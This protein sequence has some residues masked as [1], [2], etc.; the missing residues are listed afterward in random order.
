MR[1][2]RSAVLCLLVICSQSVAGTVARA[3]EPSVKPVLQPFVESHSLA[4]AVTVVASRDKV[5]STEAVGYADIAAK[6][7]ME[8]NSLFWIA[9]MSKPITGAAVMVLVD[10]GKLTID[11]PVEKYLPEFAKQTMIEDEAAER[12]T[13]KKPSRT[14]TIKDVL[15]HTSGLPFLSRSEP[16]IDLLTLKEATDI[17]AKT[18]LKS[19]P[20]TK[21]LYSNAGIGVAGRV[22]EVISGMP[23]EKF[24]EERLFKPLGMTDTTFWPNK[25]QLQRLAKSYKPNAAKN[26]LEE[27]VVTQL[28]YPL[29]GPGRCVS[30]GGGY[31][32]TAADMAAFGQM[33]LNGGIYNGKRVLS[34]S[35][36]RLM[37]STQTG[38]LLNKGQGEHGYGLG[39]STSK[40]ANPDVPVAGQCG[41]G[42][43]YATNLSV[44]PQRGLVTVWMVQHA[45]YPGD[46]NKAQGAFNKYAQDSFGKK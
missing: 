34:E 26:D 14:I 17:Y 2:P 37:T 25:E 43:A 24:V 39:W 9:S 5:L 13:F 35:S 4:G 21:Y 23:F 18:P 8:V 31:F 11:D 29:D 30:P 44:D 6:K 16:K 32:S 38:D 40:K 7:P 36:V 19:E 45:G 12:L 10:D 15:S 28:T 42:G 41:H 46:G 33:V 3:A 27:T 1:L 22:V 20:G